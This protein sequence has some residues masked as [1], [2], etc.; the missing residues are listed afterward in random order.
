[1]ANFIGSYE[2]TVDIKGRFLLPAK[3]CKQLADPEAETKRF[4]ITHGLGN[5]L[6]MYLPENWNEISE[7][8][9]ELDDLDEDARAFKSM[10]LSPAEEVES[11][12]QDRMMIPKK[13]LEYAGI[14]KEMMMIPSGNKIEL[15]NTNTRE[16]Y[17][18]DNKPKMGA[19]TQNVTQKFG[20]PFRKRNNG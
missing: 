12:N 16:A 1:M 9:S 18:N 3:F 17:I 6:L 8:L 4:V 7:N 19:I 20:S 15:W 2:V 13:L 14:S 10:F 11:D 5:Y